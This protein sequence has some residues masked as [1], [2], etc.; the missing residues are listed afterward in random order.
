M[1][2]FSL[3]DLYK[4]TSYIYSEQNIGRSIDM[5]FLH[6]VEVC[7]MLT[8][9]ARKKNRVGVTFEGSLC[10]A[11]GWFF[12][13][14][15]KCGVK[16]LEELIYRK[17]PYACPYCRK[18]PHVDAICKVVKGDIT[19]NHE[20]LKR[21]YAENLK[22]MPTS[23]NGW[24]KMFGEIYQ[25]TPDDITKSTIGLME[26]LGEL[27]EAIRVRK[28]YPKFLAGEAADIFSYFMGLANEYNLRQ[29]IEGKPL[30]DLEKEFFLR[31]PG[32]C[33]ACGNKICTC[34]FVPE[35]T[36]G[37][38]SK[39]L[40]IE[41][42]EELFLVD[43][44]SRN[45]E[46]E[47]IAKKVLHKVGGLEGLADRLPLDRGQFNSSL[48]LVCLKLQGKL[49]DIGKIDIAESLKETALKLGDNKSDAGAKYSETYMKN[50]EGVIGAMKKALK[51]IG[52]D[53]TD[54]IITS[55]DGLVYDM[56]NKPPLKILFVGAN[57]T[58]DAELGIDEEFREISEA[59]NRKGLG[60]V[61]IAVKTKITE[62]DFRRLLLDEKFD[63]VHFSGHGVGSYVG[64]VDEK[65]ESVHVPITALRKCINKNS[66]VGAV[67][68]NC[69][70]SLESETEPLSRFTVGMNDSIEDKSSI[71]FSVGFYDALLAGLDFE[72][73]VEEGV[74]S[75]DLNGGDSSMIK[76]LK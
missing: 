59:V 32:L 67:V 48:I 54:E 40:D 3:D 66:S 24:Q 37:R 57:A 8:M 22:I 4:M 35:A 33:V 45:T 58:T 10:K 61:D 42:I 49:I 52:S 73:A 21:K 19:V 69:C 20:E 46:G 47:L 16:S 18:A 9:L 26:E 53:G 7:G 12:P 17:Y 44:V 34:P 15:A 50:L 11:L 56:V 65:N 25:R 68:L 27:A 13:L 30:M 55:K 41:N 23:L 75:I 64:F 2:K 43:S 70:Y 60:K 71:H 72:R 28:L 31:Y 39:E 6:F 62:K 74:S 76:V 63:V 14:M 51:E 1:E 29:V 38:M 5:T 36:I